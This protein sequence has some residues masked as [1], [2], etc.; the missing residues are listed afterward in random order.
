[1]NG[2]EIHAHA[3]QAHARIEEILGT[4]AYNAEKWAS[5][6]SAPS[7]DLLDA[8]TDAYREASGQPAT[9]TPPPD[10]AP[11]TPPPAA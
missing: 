7:S 9:P 2:I 5:L 8:I 1:M 6:K 3:P 10:T 11:H 4:D